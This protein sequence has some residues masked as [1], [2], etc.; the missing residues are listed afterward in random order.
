MNLPFPRYA[1]SPAGTFEALIF[2]TFLK[3]LTPYF[4]PLAIPTPPDAHAQ[5]HETQAQTQ[6]HEAHAQTQLAPSR[7]GCLDVC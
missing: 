5:A 7:A 4:L 6:A 3:K 2:L 1:Y